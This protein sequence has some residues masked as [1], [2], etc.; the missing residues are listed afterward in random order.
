MTTLEYYLARSGTVRRDG[1]FKFQLTTLH[2]Q[3]REPLRRLGVCRELDLSGGARHRVEHRR[4]LQLRLVAF[5]DAHL[6]ADVEEVVELPRIWRAV[7]KTTK[8]DRG[9]VQRVEQLRSPRALGRE[10][11]G[12]PI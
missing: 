6:R 8:V 11:I 10:L 4:L 7:Q 12:L 1:V 3:L 5:D 9:L 2:E